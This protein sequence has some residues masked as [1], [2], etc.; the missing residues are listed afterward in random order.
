MENLRQAL[1]FLGG[2]DWA[3]GPRPDLLG[4]KKFPPSESWRLA[5]CDGL[6]VSHENS[7]STSRPTT[8]T[9][10]TKVDANVQSH[11]GTGPHQHLSEHAPVLC[12][13]PEHR[14][15]VE[16]QPPSVWRAC[17][18]E[19]EVMEADLGLAQGVGAVN[20]A[21]RE[22]LSGLPDQIPIPAANPNGRGFC[23]PERLA[24][25]GAPDMTDRLRAQQDQGLGN[26]DRQTNDAFTGWTP[27]A[28]ASG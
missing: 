12:V 18:A 20:V 23:L 26:L 17:G 25:K 13:R 1:H 6:P 4:C 15:G 21:K 22:E 9:R 7:G 2:K 3:L 19:N 11:L 28:S 16:G 14:P 8:F 24:L 10:E 5:R 27:C